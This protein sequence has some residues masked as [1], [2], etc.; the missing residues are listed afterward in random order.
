MTS[1]NKSRTRE[2]YYRKLFGSEHANKP[3]DSVDAI[4]ERA[5]KGIKASLVDYLIMRN[6]QLVD[7]DGTVFES[8]PVVYVAK[9]VVRD[10]EGNYKTANVYNAIKYLET[11]VEVPADY[12]STLPT[13][14]LNC[15]I[16]IHAFNH[17]V[18]KQENGTYF[19]MDVEWKIVLDQYAYCSFESSWQ[20]CA[21]IVDGLRSRIIDNPK[22]TDFPNEPNYRG[23]NINRNRIQRVHRFNIERLDHKLL[24]DI[25]RSSYLYMFFQNLTGQND[26]SIFGDIAEYINWTFNRT[27]EPFLWGPI[28]DKYNSVWVG[29]N[30]VN[31]GFA[32]D[33]PL[34]HKNSFR[35]VL[36]EEAASANIKK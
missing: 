24:S 34:E 23:E 4:I 29:S 32:A 26:L 33:V 36:L 11:E 28:I 18:E 3:K 6:V 15:A 1:E 16:L 19:T 30:L 8:H 35:G 9:D 7:S 5:K 31:L 17:G 25:D 10:E 20:A 21:T 13:M 12:F 27:I 2:S 14:A 22:D